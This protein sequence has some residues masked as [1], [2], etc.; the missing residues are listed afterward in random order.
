MKVRHRH[1]AVLAR[2]PLAISDRAMARSAI[3]VVSLLTP[4]QQRDGYRHRNRLHKIGR[5]RDMTRID[6]V[7]LVECAASDRARY[8][9]SGAELVRKEFIEG[10]R[11]Q[12][13]LAV[14]IR[15][16]FDGRAARFVTTEASYADYQHT[17]QKP[18]EQKVAHLFLH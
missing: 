2:D 1:H 14:H 10:L 3:D 11:A 5:S 4:C 15:E 9:H 13:R 16:N 18:S 6:F 12:L 17:E 7:F 8:R